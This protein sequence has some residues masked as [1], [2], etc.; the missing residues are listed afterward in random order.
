MI[1]YLFFLF[2]LLIFLLDHLSN[3]RF[4]NKSYTSIC[5]VVVVNKGERRKFTFCFYFTKCNFEISPIQIIV[6][7]CWPVTFQ[8]FILGTTGWN[9]LN[10]LGIEISSL[11]TAP[12]KTLPLGST[13]L[14]LPGCYL[15]RASI[16]FPFLLC[17][18]VFLGLLW[19][20]VLDIVWVNAR[21][22]WVTWPSSLGGKQ[23][24]KLS[25]LC[26]L[27][28]ISQIFVCGILKSFL[29]S[30]LGPK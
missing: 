12:G 6:L 1:T 23:T 27:E 19:K 22:I 14:N 20:S 11:P 29:W 18:H 24:M 17:K 28:N 15:T 9:I 25:V 3:Y 30:L 21:N 16:S 4:H 10:L 7:L 26:E 5:N 8:H 2:S 13:T